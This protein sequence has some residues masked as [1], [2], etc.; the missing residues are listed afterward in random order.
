LQA[1]VALKLDARLEGTEVV[2]V[3][4][5]ESIENDVA[6]LKM[7]VGIYDSPDD[8]EIIVGW[9]LWRQEKDGNM[10][11][12]KYGNITFGRAASALDLDEKVVSLAPLKAIDEK[13]TNYTFKILPCPISEVDSLGRP[14]YEFKAGRKTEATLL[15]D[16][17]VPP[18][19]LNITTG[20]VWWHYVIIGAG[21]L[22]VCLL[23]C[24][25]ISHFQTKAEEA[26]EEKEEYK[27]EL[28]REQLGH[29]WDHN[30]AQVYESKLFGRKSKKQDAAID[31]FE[32][33]QV[34]GDDKI[35]HKTD[36]SIKLNSDARTEFNAR[37]SRTRSGSKIN[38]A[39]WS[40]EQAKRFSQDMSTPHGS[41]DNLNDAPLPPPPDMK[42]P[43]NEEAGN[44]VE[45]QKREPARIA[46]EQPKRIAVDDSVT[47]SL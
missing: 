1:T 3:D 45:L 35:E 18:Q 17:Y 38:T 43:V 2:F 47:F 46:S 12:T 36:F 33:I 34:D 6:Q 19:Q 16:D 40:D 21:V 5:I 42:A 13:R 9:E 4:H 31:R 37:Q 14:W 11:R 29:F 20:F 28:Q 23:S 27:E 25:C 8:R 22:F 44:E 26:V 32:L 7:R 30:D 41:S 39:N 24:F 15:I 10:T